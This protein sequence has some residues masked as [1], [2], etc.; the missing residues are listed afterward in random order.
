MRYQ[1]IIILVFFLLT[2][3]G[4]QAQ[5]KESF[6]VIE[7]TLNGN[8][9][10][11]SFNMAYRDFKQKSN[12]PWCLTISI[13]LD[14]KNLYPN[15]LPLPEETQIAND[16]QDQLVSKIKKITKVEY[17]GHLFN[18]AFL[19]IYIYL[20][21]PDRVHEFLQIEKDKE[22]LIRGIAY[23]IKE[24]PNWATVQGFLTTK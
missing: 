9:I 5:T 16:I 17:V 3:S 8:P 21:K 10:I 2:L 22:S 24:D 7:S 1:K 14:L 18:D 12:Y 23:E 19:D 11:C 13:A 20:N 15:K 6:S 4:C